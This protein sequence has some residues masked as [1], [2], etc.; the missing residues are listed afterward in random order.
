[1]AHSNISYLGRL[2]STAEEFNFKYVKLCTRRGTYRFRRDG[3]S[4]EAPSH[5]ESEEEAVKYFREKVSYAH[6]TSLQAFP[7]NRQSG[8]KRG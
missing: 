1:M 6:K 8:P 2:I 5:P 3:I 4:V 7:L